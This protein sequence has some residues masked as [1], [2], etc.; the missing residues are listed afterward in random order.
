MPA[1]RAYRGFLLARVLALCLLDPACAV[2]LNK[3][4]RHG[5]PTAGV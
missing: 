4:N 1:S 5:D 2:E 3:V